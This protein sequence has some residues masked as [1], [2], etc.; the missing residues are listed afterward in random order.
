VAVF[1]AVL[2][3]VAVAVVRRWLLVR[4]PCGGG[5]RNGRRACGRRGRGLRRRV[6]FA[7]TAVVAVAVCE[8]DTVLALIV[9][10]DNAGAIAGRPSKVMG[11]VPW[12][13]SPKLV[14]MGEIQRVRSTT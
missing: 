8:S 10:R 6:I 7:R 4:G 9:Q 2:L 14:C 1:V 5:W 11:T 13:R 12:Y 3:P